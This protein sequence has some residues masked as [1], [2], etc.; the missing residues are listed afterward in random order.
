[1]KEKVAVIAILANAVLA[2]GKVAVGLM[3]SSGA[4]LTDG[5]HS[6]VDVFSSAISLVGIKIAKKPADEKHPYGHYK[7]E[8]FAG[9]IIAIILFIT[10]LLIIIEAIN[11]LNK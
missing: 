4:I 10:G 6:G 11:K 1:M 8:V 9:L 7:F 5:L 3:A 2:G